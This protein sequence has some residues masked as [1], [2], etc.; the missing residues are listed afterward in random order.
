MTSIVPFV[1]RGLYAATIALAATVCGIGLTA[2]PTQAARPAAGVASALPTITLYVL[3]GDLTKKVGYKGPDGRYHDSIVSSTITVKMG[4]PTRVSVV[5]YDEGTHSITSP[6]LGLSFTIASGHHET[7]KEKAAVDRRERALGL[8][9]T[10][11]PATTTFTLNIKKRGTYRWFCAMP[12][13][14]QN[15]KW[16]MLAGFGGPGQVGYM[17]GF[18]VVV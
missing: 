10:T 15:G 7:D 2:H 9:E 1:R 16:A 14:G 17:A 18:I 5:N 11:S 12:C 13:D 6:T 3:P 4:Q 8:S